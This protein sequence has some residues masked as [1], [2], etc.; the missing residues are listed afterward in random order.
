MRSSREKQTLFVSVGLQVA[1]SLLY[2]RSWPQG[3]QRR[4]L[5]WLRS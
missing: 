2:S 4:L 5:S 1:E 3:S